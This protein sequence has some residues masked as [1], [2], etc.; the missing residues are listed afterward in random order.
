MELEKLYEQCRTYREFR[1]DP[2]P[3]ELMEKILRVASRRSS[4]RNAQP[5][6]YVAVLSPEKVAELQPFVKWAASIPNNGGVPRPGMEPVAW[7]AVS[8]IAQSGDSFAYIDMGIAVDAIVLTACEA[9]YGSCIF[10]AINAPKIKE[11]L[12]IPEEQE[13]K[14]MIALGKPAHES[15]VMGPREDGKLA[16]IR[17]ENRNY[18]V[19][20][21]PL[22][23]VARFV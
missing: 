20:K 2:V 9:G 5:N 16:Y 11:A 23:E 8:T 22:D 4:A 14:L 6:R 15:T 10:G 18:H 12:A 17:D 3:R 13:L 7:I 21:H 19:P 1:Q